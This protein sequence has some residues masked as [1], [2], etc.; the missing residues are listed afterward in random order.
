MSDSY[1]EAIRGLLDGGADIL[2]IETIF[3]TANAKVINATQFDT[4][5][6]L[7]FKKIIV[8]TGRNLRNRLCIRKRISTC[9]SICMYIEKDSI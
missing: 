7:R 8:I 2:M 5:Q 9:S 4:Y 3:D 6:N 1:Y